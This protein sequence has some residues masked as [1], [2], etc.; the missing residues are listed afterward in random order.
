MFV[1]A[2][3]VRAKTTAKTSAMT[4]GSSR[5]IPPTQVLGVLVNYQVPTDTL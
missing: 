1:A 4:K 3:R 5:V 2:I